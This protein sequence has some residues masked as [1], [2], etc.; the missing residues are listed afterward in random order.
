MFS[1][2]NLYYILYVNLFKRIKADVN[3][4]SVF[5]SIDLKDSCRNFFPSEMA[6]SSKTIAFFHDQEP[7]QLKTLDKFFFSYIHH[8]KQNYILVTSEKSDLVKEYCKKNNVYHLYYFFHGFACLDWYNDCKFFPKN[9]PLFSRKFLSFNRLCTHLRSY[10]LLLVSEL[11]DRDILKY[12][13]VSLQFISN[14]KNIIKKELVD[15]NCRLSKKSKIKVYKNLAALKNNLIIDNE[16]LGNASAHLGAKEY[17]LWQQSFLHVI[18]ETVFFDVKQHLTEKI[19]KPIVSQRPF[20]L[21]GA[22]K[23]LEYFK[24]YGF[25]T[26]SKWIDESYDDEPDNEKRLMMACDEIEKI[27]KLSEDEIESMYWDMQEVLEY[28]YQHFYTDF[29]QIIVNELVDNFEGYMRWYNNGRLNDEVYDIESLNL[30]E[31]KQLLA[32]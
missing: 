13:S 32:Q 18:S 5:G 27:A 15:Y 30:P 6:L 16:V 8:F 20:I 7:V 26:F 31:V 4:F 10:R 1:I 17:T 19:F 22:Y 24:S 12:G 25:K 2:E 11:V 9:K 21:L 28:N 23:N 29:K 3:Y 14:E